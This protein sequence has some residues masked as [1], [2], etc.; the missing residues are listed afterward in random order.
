M[1]HGQKE[2][3]A[4]MGEFKAGLVTDAQREIV[5]FP[6]MLLIHDLVKLS[7]GTPIK[8]GSQNIHFEKQGAFTGEVSASQVKETGC[9]YALIGHSE[10]RQY[11]NETSIDCGKKIAAASAVGL[12]PMY[13]IGENQSQRDGNQTQ[14][15]LS[16]QLAE[17]LKLWEQ[18]KGPLVIAYEPVWAIGTGKVATPP[19]VEETHSF[20]RSFLTKK[21][22]QQASLIPILYGGSVKPENSRELIA[23]P[24]VDGFLVGGASL[25]AKSFAQI[26]QLPL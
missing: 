11:F 25:Q 16:E 1:Y 6:P 14:S 18:E 22:G 9:Q 23:L 19:M 13:C 24:N 26:A 21:L 5:I 12:I 20:I 2:A 10:R 15:V 17:G 7:S 3:S 4:F 8:I